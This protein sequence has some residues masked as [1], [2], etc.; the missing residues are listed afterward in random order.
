VRG[1]FYFTPRQAFTAIAVALA[2]LLVGLIIY[3]IFFLGGGPGLSTR[4]GDVKAGIRPIFTIEGPGTGASPRFQRPMGAAFGIDGRIYVTDT[5]NNRVCVFDSSGRFL[6]EF[7]AFGVGKPL[8]GAKNTN[9]PGRLNYPVGIA[10]D[11]NGTVYVA[12]FRN[13]QI[14]V[15]D[16]DGKP[17]RTFPDNRRPT[18]KGSSGQDGQGIA[19]TD[20]SVRDGK[21]YATDTY[22]V[23]VFDL[24]GK[25]L[26]QFGKPGVGPG[27]LDHPNGVT[28][29]GKG[30]IW[31]SDSNHARVSVF[32]PDY[33][34]RFSVG[35][36]LATP[37]G[38]TETVAGTAMS[39]PRGITTLDDD[40]TIVVDAFNFELVH[41]S[42]VGEVIGRYGERGVAPGQFNFPNDVDASGSLLLVTDKENNRVQVVEL[43]GR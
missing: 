33:K 21:V 6:F 10:A 16:P 25:V 2:G 26:A 8:P 7:G 36:D 32:G 27:D 43:V 28:A 3:L 31:V 19:V 40:S 42:P 15:F 39:L 37:V 13:D 12:S 11:D 23:F 14:A 20:V 17:L 22:Q 18:G 24:T 38:A 35:K 4:G 1:G 30:R 9:K 41:I 5:G 29:D 34:V